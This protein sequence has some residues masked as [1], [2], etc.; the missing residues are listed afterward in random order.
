MYRIV[1]TATNGTQSA[2]QSVFVR[3][4]AFK[5]QT[6]VTTSR[7]GSPVVVTAVSVEPLSGAPVLIVKQPGRPKLTLTMVKASK[8]TWTATATPRRSGDAGTLTLIVK[9]RDTAGGT[10]TTTLRLPLE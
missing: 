8:T 9:G 6:S 4:D 2:T 10:N 5:A 7:R 3:A 1:V